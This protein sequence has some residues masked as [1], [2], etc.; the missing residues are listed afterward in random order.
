MACDL[1]KAVGTL[2]VALILL[3]LMVRNSITVLPERVAS[4]RLELSFWN[5]HAVIKL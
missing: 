3:V 4:F 2:G 1:F 5:G